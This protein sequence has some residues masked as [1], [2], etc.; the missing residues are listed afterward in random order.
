[1]AAVLTGVKHNL[2]K[3]G[4]YLNDCRQAGIVVEIP[5]VNSSEVDFSSKNA[6]IFGVLKSPKWEI[7]TL[8]W[9]KKHHLDSESIQN[10]KK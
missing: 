10:H 1:M 6:E 2:D 5:D 3:A 4:L 8:E 9:G 7:L